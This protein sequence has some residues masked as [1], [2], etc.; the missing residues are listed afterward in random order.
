[1]RLARVAVTLAALWHVAL[2]AL[3][4][5]LLWFSGCDGTDC[6][7][8]VAPIVGI[9]YLGIAGIVIVPFGFWGLARLRDRR[10]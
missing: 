10:Q 3:V 8:A 4:V 1:M 5:Y 6:N 2:G 9:L 7:A